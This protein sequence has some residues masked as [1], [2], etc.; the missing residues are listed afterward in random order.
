MVISQLVPFA[1]SVGIAAAALSTMTLVVGAFGNAS[2]RILS[3]WM[4]D[5]LGR[6]N[7]LRTMIA[8]SI[9]AMPALYAAGDRAPVANA[10]FAVS[11]DAAVDLLEAREY[12]DLPRQERVSKAQAEQQGFLNGFF[13]PGL[14]AALDLRI[15]ADPAASTPVS[16]TL[17]G[18]VWGASADGVTARAE[19]LR[20]QVH[21][22]MP[23]HVSATPV[24]DGS[25]VAR[26]LT[27][28]ARGGADSAVITRHELIGLP[29]RPDAGIPYYF[30]AVPFNWSDND[31]SAVYAAPRPPPRL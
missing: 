15:A 20:R 10:Y 1:K 7:V 18:R 31:W 24:A 12:K 5:K 25:A 19:G 26:L 30:S 8:I 9:V 22:A 13:D 14:G 21:A 4:S 2:G 23:R 6:I 11:V 28:F 29:S 3:G 16:V 17:L 27:P